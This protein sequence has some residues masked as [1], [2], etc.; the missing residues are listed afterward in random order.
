MITSDIKVEIHAYLW[1]MWCRKQ[2][3]DRFLLFISFLL[4]RSCYWKCIYKLPLDNGPPAGWARTPSSSQ[5]GGSLRLPIIYLT[6]YTLLY[7]L[8]MI[9]LNSTDWKYSKVA[10]D[11]IF[12]HKLSYMFSFFIFFMRFRIYDFKICASLDLRKSFVLLV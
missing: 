1:I 12:V 10:S 7:W 8:Y 2:K 9:C 3:I 5:C 6:F 11:D 4:H